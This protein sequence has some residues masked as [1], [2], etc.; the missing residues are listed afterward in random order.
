MNPGF[1]ST[2]TPPQPVAGP[3]F[4]FI[5]RKY[6]LLVH[7]ATADAPAR[8]PRLAD[9]ATLGLTLQHRQYL[10]YCTDEERP[11]HAFTADISP[12]TEPPPGMGFYNL[13]RLFG[14]FEDENI[15][16]LA[17]RAVQIIDWDRT[18]QFC[19]R[20]GAPTEQQS[21]ERAKRCPQC[22]AAIYPRLSPAIIVAV[23]RHDAAPSQLLLARSW[24]HPADLYSVI[25]GFVEPGETLETAVAREVKEETDIDVKDVRYF[26]S[27]PWP[28][29]NSLMIAYTAEYAGGEIELEEEEM[30]D[31]GWYTADSLPQ[32][33]PPISIARS[34]IEWF[35]ETGGE[36]GGGEAGS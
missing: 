7:E 24:R 12:D 30:A 31:A 18:S 15:I 25:A 6:E 8:I 32:I 20:C 36:R 21:H 1:V 35:V 16:W 14:L 26:G 5:F 17:G 2:V 27:Q 19:G 3:A 4:W 28:F 10:G 34:L 11:F 29:P 23:V 9:P 33:P 13:R 22:D